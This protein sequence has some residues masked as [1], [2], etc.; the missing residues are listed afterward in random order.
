MVLVLEKRFLL[1]HLDRHPCLSRIYVIVLL[2]LSWTLFAITDLSALGQYFVRMF[3]FTGGSDW[4]Y[5]L[6]N[7]GVTLL[8]CG[9][10][11]TPVL[12]NFYEKHL[13]TRKWLTT[14]LLCGVLL[15]SVAYLVDATYNPFLYF[16]F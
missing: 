4:I 9:F 6:R 1:P 14:L 10:F 11:S 16:R 8:L 5:Y 7:Y 3:S 15:L 13:A 2:I 12:K